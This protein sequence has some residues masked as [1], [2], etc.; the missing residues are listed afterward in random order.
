VPAALLGMS[1]KQIKSFKR[2]AIGMS[3]LGNSLGHVCLLCVDQDHSCHAAQGSEPVKEADKM[4][5][6]TIE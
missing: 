5:S 1:F 6:Q 2:L 3:L 4:G